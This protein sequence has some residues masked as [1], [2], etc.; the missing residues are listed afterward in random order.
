MRPL[1]ELRPATWLSSLLAGLTTWVTLLAWTKFAENPAGFMVPIL[2]ACLLVAGSGMVLRAARVPAVPVAL[3]QVLVVLV[4]LH[5]REVSHLAVAGWVPTPD[6]VRGL[7]SALNESALVSQAYAAP[8]PQSAP[9]FYVLMILAGSLTA[10]LID[11]LAVGLRRAPLAGLPLLALYTAPVS[12]LDGG[13][14]WLKFAAAALC[15]LFL[16]AAEEA[17][18]LA[19][20]GHQLV[21]GGRIFDTQTTAVSGQAVWAS[22]RKIGLTATGLAVVVPLFIPTV[23]ASLFSGGGGSGAG[24]GDGVSISNPMVDLKRDLTQGADV[25]LVRVTTTEN[26]PSYLRISVLNAFDGNAWRP[27]DRDIPVKQRADGAVA[28]PPGLD[29]TVPTKEVQAT[30]QASDEF[31]S[32]WL[33]TPYPVSSVDA[34]GDW[35]YDRST[36]DFISAAD[37]QT[38]AGITY[39]LRGLDLTPSA[40]ELADATPA[41]ASVF[42]PN[43]A[44]PRDLPGSVRK[45]ARQVTDGQTTKFEKAVALQRWFRVD[46]HFRYSLKR[47]PGN[48]TDDLVTFLGT[49]K[50]GR[51]GYCEQFAASM[52]LMGRSLGIPSRVA[53]GFLRPER[54]GRDTF[55]YSSH[56]LHAWPEMYFGGV[57]W[58]RF[59]P[60]PQRTSDVPAY[61]TQRVPQA[62]PAQKSSAPAAAPTLNRIDRT[63]DPAAAAAKHKSGSPW[64]S[65]VA[66]G[67]ALV[68]LVLVLLLLAPRTAR[69]VLRRRR[70]AAAT[71]PAALVEAGWSEVRDTALDLGL[72]FDDHVTL[73]SSAAELVHAFGRPGDED[74]ALGRGSH[75]GPD[76]D[77]E[78]TAALNRLVRLVE[79]ARYSRALP[80]GATSAEQVH[81]DVASCVSAMR[82]GAGRHR[83]TR[84]TWLPASLTSSPASARRRSRRGSTLE[85]GV[86]RAV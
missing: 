1:R 85:A 16:I 18:R 49:G 35:R 71:E 29:R 21:P 54:V 70:W 79:R 23:S 53:V 72:T 60:T 4:W 52:A 40:A 64:T 8:V 6:S 39:R 43:T 59:E 32:R 83:R 33:P 30:L 50:N 82:A 41:P 57:G 19:H 65:P 31:K 68:L 51:V 22:A 26:D 44:L 17:Q 63:T 62:D 69:S 24:N 42:T 2:G 48:S 46:G 74:D 61:T 80:P 28:R 45:L 86:D 76:A 3:A 73:R 75:R 67:S 12:I 11:F 20:W 77:P 5:H 25:E 84:A 10:V 47:A 14:S 38:T 55:V 37:N 78:A 66:V 36:L 34:P 15:F 56:D 81:A 9:E 58:V 13:V 27:A 7:M